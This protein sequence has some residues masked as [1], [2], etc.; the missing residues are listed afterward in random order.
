MREVTLVISLCLA[1]AKTGAAQDT[2]TS[3]GDATAKVPSG[4]PFARDDRDAVRQAI[5]EATGRD[6][7]DDA[8]IQWPPSFPRLVVVGTFAHDRGCMYEGL[9]V[10]RTWYAGRDA[11]ADVAGL[12]T[13]GWAKADIEQRQKIARDWV[14]EVAQAFDGRFVEKPTTAFAF[15]D[16]PDFE[17]VHVRPTKVMGVVVDGWVAEPSGMVFEEAYRFVE[18]RFGPD[19]TVQGSSSRQFAVPGERIREREQSQSDAE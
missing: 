2:K 12:S 1:C 17:P 5:Q 9:F 3:E 13:V 19:A 4:E 11:K 18:Y 10:D 14:R 16:T 7:G 8:C 6:P 15:D